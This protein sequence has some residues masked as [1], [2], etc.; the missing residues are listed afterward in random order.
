MTIKTFEQNLRPEYF[1]PRASLAQIYGEYGIHIDDD[2]VHEVK[3]GDRFYLSEIELLVFPST[4]QTA[5]EAVAYLISTA[6]GKIF[7][8][9]DVLYVPSFFD[10]VKQCEPDIAFLPLGKNPAGWNVYPDKADFV[11]LAE[12]IAA[13][14]TIP[15]HWDL[16]NESYI[17]AGDL[18][19][20]I[21]NPR[22]KVVP[23][24]TKLLLPL[25]DKP[26]VT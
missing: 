23:R 2:R 13:K 24:G 10:A 8:P 20:S 21:R 17:D 12:E 1:L 11:K 22:I 4:D 18:E 6:E 3:A 26:V 19:N 9:G 16:W 5:Q 25:E 7:H 15:I 14:L